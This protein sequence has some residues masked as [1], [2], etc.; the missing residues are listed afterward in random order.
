[1]RLR[2]ALARIGGKLPK[3]CALGRDRDTGCVD[4][5]RAPV[6]VRRPAP[7]AA[8]RCEQR[9]HSGER[10]APRPPCLTSLAP[11]SPAGHGHSSAHWTVTDTGIRCV[12]GSAGG[13]FWRGGD[14]RGLPPCSPTPPWPSPL[15]PVLAT[16][17]LELSPVQPAPTLTS[18][19]GCPLSRRPA[20]GGQHIR[21]L[22]VAHLPRHSW[23]YPVT[24]GRSSRA[25]KGRLFKWRC[26]ARAGVL[27]GSVLGQTRVHDPPGTRDRRRPV[28]GEGSAD[29]SGGAAGR[30]AA[31]F[32]GGQVAADYGAQVIGPPSRLQ[33]NP[34][35]P[36]HPPVGE[37]AAVG[38]DDRC[39]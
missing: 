20:S 10:A 12:L 32:G 9:V 19:S 33:G 7:P 11:P 27:R 8:R 16:A 35:Q 3:N 29:P 6:R 39:L 18:C 1:M 13:L 17:G 26:A 14:R 25:A 28:R 34:G 4:C 21:R 36:G 30:Q 2:R 23:R 37:R 15:A 22:P 24:T 5:H 38:R 31:P